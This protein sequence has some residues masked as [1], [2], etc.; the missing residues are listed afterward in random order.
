MKNRSKVDKILKIDEMKIINS[1]SNNS[2][3]VGYE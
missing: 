1:I 2:E 3:R